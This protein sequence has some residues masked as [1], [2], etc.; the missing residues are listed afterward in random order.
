MTTN[1]ANLQMP[2][3]IPVNSTAITI[4]TCFAEEA[5]KLTDLKSYFEVHR[6]L[7]DLLDNDTT[8]DLVNWFDGRPKSMYL[9][10]LTSNQA[11]MAY[12]FSQDLVDED[13]TIEISIRDYLQCQDLSS[14]SVEALFDE[15]MVPQ[16]NLK[17]AE[18]GHLIVHFG[19]ELICA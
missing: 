13:L 5:S 8:K 2:L 10:I 12:A 15:F 19:Y 4:S 7:I 1:L 6:R 9:T 18:G 11:A 14:E 17:Q 3:T 16:A